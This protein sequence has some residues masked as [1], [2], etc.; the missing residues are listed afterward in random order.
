MSADIDGLY[1]GMLDADELRWFEEQIAVGN[2]RRDYD[3]PGGLLGLAK[4]KIL[5]RT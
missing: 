5:K 3:H 1:V 2:A 4:V